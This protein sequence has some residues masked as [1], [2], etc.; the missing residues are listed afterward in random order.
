MNKT[1]VKL[2]FI[3]LFM[4]AFSFAIHTVII[5]SQYVSQGA[6]I[7]RLEK[8]SRALSL[9][10]QALEHQIAQS[11]A[12]VGISELASAQGFQPVSHIIALQTGFVASR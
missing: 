8:S 4:I 7:S 1:A 10:T 12:S 9:Q 5:G 6:E 3:F 11:S 2:Y